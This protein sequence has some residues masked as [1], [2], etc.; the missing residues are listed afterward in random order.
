MTDPPNN[1]VSK[2]DLE[3]AIAG[4]NER[5]AGVNERF[6]TLTLDMQAH[7]ADVRAEIA[8][9]RQLIGLTATFL[10]TAI[11]ATLGLLIKLVFFP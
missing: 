9:V 11:G 7:F 10:F 2:L 6:A 8:S 3:Q 1:L 5:F 4:V